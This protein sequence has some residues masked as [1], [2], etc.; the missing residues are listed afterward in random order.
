MSLSEPVTSKRCSQTILWELLLRGKP[1][2]EMTVLLGGRYVACEGVGCLAR[3]EVP[4][5]LH[6]ILGG[7]RTSSSERIEGWLFVANRGVWHHYCHNCLPSY[8][9]SLADD[10]R[11]ESV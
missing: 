7:V 6:P 11:N 2:S 8:L 10:D 9:A 3:A 5:A 1:Q 4:I